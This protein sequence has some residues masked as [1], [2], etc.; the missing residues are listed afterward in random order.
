MSMKKTIILAL[1]SIVLAG[2]ETTDQQ[3]WATALQNMGGPSGN[4][5]PRKYYTQGGYQTQQEHQQYINSINPPK[6]TYEVQDQYGIPTGY[7]LEEK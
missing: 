5:Q 6:K 1:F 4:Y 2:C 3:R 7:Y